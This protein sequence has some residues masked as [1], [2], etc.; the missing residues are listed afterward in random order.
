M[1]S[2]GAARQ[3][4][5]RASSGSRRSYL[6]RWWEAER[7]GFGG[8]L[9]YG[10]SLRAQPKGASGAGS[11][12]GEAVPAVAASEQMRSTAGLFWTRHRFSGSR[13]HASPRC[14]DV[15]PGGGK[16]SRFGLGRVFGFHVPMR[17]RLNRAHQAQQTG[18]PG[19]EPPRFGNHTGCALLPM[20]PHRVFWGGPKEA[21]PAFW[22][23]ESCGDRRLGCPGAGTQHPQAQG[24]G[25]RGS[26]SAFSGMT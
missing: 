18:A 20:Q 17:M 7:G 3:P 5:G 10:R 25:R 16:S 8:G 26:T 1:T 23:A 4:G 6:G 14:W 19:R 13:S 11:P 24:L 15:T 21:D 12:P 22:K 2:D 9:D